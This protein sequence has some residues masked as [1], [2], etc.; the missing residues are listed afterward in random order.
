MSGVELILCLAIA[1]LGVLPVLIGR[2]RWWGV[3]GVLVA[4]VV[5]MFFYRPG[6]G[7]SAGDHD[8]P[9]IVA[10][11]DYVSSDACRSCHPSEHASWHATYHRTMTQL[12]T[13]ET[14]L[15]PFDDIALS[16]R[17]RDYELEHTDDGF[18]VTMA[19][20]DEERLLQRAGEDLS[21]VS[22]P[23]HVRRKVVMTT[24]SHHMQGYWV[25]SR[26][27]NMLLQVP[28]YYLIE[29]ARWVPRED[30]FI[31]PPDD[32]R[33]F[34]TWNDGCI[35]C[36]S[37]DGRPLM[38]IES[39]TGIPDSEVAEFGISCEACHGP[40]GAHVRRH[41]S[42]IARYEQH[43]SDQPDPTIINPANLTHERSSE[44]CGACHSFSKFGKPRDYFEFGPA[45]RPGDR[46]DEHYPIVKLS[47]E[48]D[49]GDRAR[50]IFWSDGVCRTGG[51]ELNGMSESACY[52]EGAMSCLSCHSMHNSAPND[53]LAARME[54]NDACLQ[55]H[56]SYRDRLAEHT[57]HP[58]SS[59]GSLCYN[60]HMPHTSYALLT[61]MRSH[62]IDSPRVESSVE[63]GRPNACNLCHLDKT[64]EWS[65]V[66]LT[67]WY[68]QE[69]V[70]LEDAGRTVAA[71]LEWLYRGD[72]VQRA[73]IAW[74][75][76]WEE[77]Q[78]ASGS[79]WLAPHLAHT[80]DDPYSAVRFVGVRSL[81]SLP[82]LRGLRI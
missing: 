55:C 68:G 82:G 33:H 20:P 80:L 57:H 28:W 7:P 77:A 30:V 26:Y 72:A 21:R 34:P 6:A 35:K 13:E 46:L 8:L 74:S 61:A 76:G 60:C 15:A 79:D 63:F 64:L 42:P 36:H 67:D 32:V 41:R 18:F 37:V 75:M 54:G 11:R 9:R 17:G 23:P 44:V 27:G 78:S 45:F 47:P 56:P 65:A 10:E 24:G 19:N 4:V 70:E 14:V 50:D 71:S 29:E 1:A 69:P 81:R 43:H 66:H 39:G 38:D 31:A 40:G 2:V 59:S 3:S 53:Q 58:V 49:A 73:V 25:E 51:D 52:Q 5:G 12:A 16:S 22:S 48:M 62:H